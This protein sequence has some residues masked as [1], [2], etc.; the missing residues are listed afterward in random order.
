MLPGAALAKSGKTPQMVSF[1]V[2][3]HSG[4]ALTVLLTNKKTGDRAYLN[5]DS[6][7]TTEQLLQGMY[8]YTVT[9]PCGLETGTW[10]VTPGRMLWI[11]CKYGFPVAA[12]VKAG[13][14][15][16]LGVYYH[17]SGY[18]MFATLRTLKPGGWNSLQSYLDS[19][20]VGDPDAFIDCW[21]LSSGA[22]YPG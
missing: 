7:V 16:E 14:S 6:G 1:N 4:T 9:T 17:D 20:K 2:Y 3:N 13:S 21:S 5:L 19:V 11:S 10:N 18:F 15:C 22:I 12:L 8:D